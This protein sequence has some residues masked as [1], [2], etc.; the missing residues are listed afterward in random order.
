WQE[1]LT[2][3]KPYFGSAYPDVFHGMADL[4]VYFFRQGLR[5]VR[6]GGRLA[7]ISSNSWLQTSYAEPLRPFVRTNTR[8]ESL[9][10][11][12]NKRTVAEAPDV[13]PSIFVIDHTAP[14][15]EHRFSCTVFARGEPP[16]LAPAVLRRRAIRVAQGDQP[17]SGWQ[18]EEDAGRD[19]FA[20]IAS[21]G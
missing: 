4:F 8:L 7:Y 10:D 19:L 20:K 16:T 13:C 1:G 2:G 3:L 15:P 14:P 17:D 9:V 21:A 18:L 11:L 12:G 6:R 5:L